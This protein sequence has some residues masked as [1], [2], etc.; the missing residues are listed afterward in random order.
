MQKRRHLVHPNF[1]VVMYLLIY[2]KSIIENVL[3]DLVREFP[4]ILRVFGQQNSLQW[5]EDKKG[6]PNTQK[7]ILI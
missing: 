4:I 3:L 7:K 1:D 5:K 6:N 2:K